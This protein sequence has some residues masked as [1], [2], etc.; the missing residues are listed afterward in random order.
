MHILQHGAEKVQP[1]CVAFYKT[2][3]RENNHRTFGRKIGSLSARFEESDQPSVKLHCMFIERE[4]EVTIYGAFCNSIIDV[5]WVLLHT[6]LYYVRASGGAHTMPSPRIKHSLS[7]FQFSQCRTRRITVKA[8]LYISLVAANEWC[9][10]ARFNNPGQMRKEP[11]LPRTFM[12]LCPFLY[13]SWDASYNM[14]YTPA[15]WNAI[16]I[17]SWDAHVV[18]IYP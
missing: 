15:L 17:C 16:I 14:I 1:L 12:I 7:L 3:Q 10:H 6:Q 13:T 5:C 9:M 4:R 2:N 8:L 11:R 18:Y